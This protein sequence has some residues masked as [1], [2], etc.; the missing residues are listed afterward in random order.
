MNTETSWSMMKGLKR[1]LIEIYL[2]QFN[3]DPFVTIYDG[4]QD[5][6]EDMGFANY[7]YKQTINRTFAH[8]KGNPY[9]NT[10]GIHTI[11][12]DQP[13][14]VTFIFEKMGEG[15]DFAKDY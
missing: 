3:N 5:L 6:A 7:E 10:V 12:F 11:N 8:E 4:I 13:R 9:P 14:Q 2:V 1:R 15:D